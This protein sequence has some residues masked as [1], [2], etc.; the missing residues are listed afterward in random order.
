MAGVA[1]GDGSWLLSPRN[2]PG[3][4]LSP[5]PGPSA[6]FSVEVVAIAVAGRDGELTSASRTIV[7]PPPPEAVDRAPAPIPLGLDAQ[8]LSA[9]APFDAIIVLDVPGGATL[10]AG[11]YDPAIDA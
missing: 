5:P 3:L 4:L 1:S 10:S 9:G 2:L 8:Q 7:V 6:G 11:T